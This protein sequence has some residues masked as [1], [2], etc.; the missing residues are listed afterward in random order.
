MSGLLLE[1]ASASLFTVSLGVVP[2][3]A[4]GTVVSVLYP[5]RAEHNARQAGENEQLAVSP[6]TPNN[7]PQ[8]GEVPLSELLTPA[9]VY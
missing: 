2:A 6:E 1:V 8:S 5:V 7:L 3:R 4:A 9:P